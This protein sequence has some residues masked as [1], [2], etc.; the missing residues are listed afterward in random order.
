M[1]SG[2]VVEICHEGQRRKSM[3]SSQRLVTSGVYCRKGVVGTASQ[4]GCS[5]GYRLVQ[6]GEYI[7]GTY[8]FEICEG[9]DLEWTGLG[10]VDRGDVLLQDISE[11]VR[12]DLEVEVFPSG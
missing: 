1:C 9:L 5:N 11:T 8:V 3:S 12:E 2:A 7:A 6:Q 10:V 4:L